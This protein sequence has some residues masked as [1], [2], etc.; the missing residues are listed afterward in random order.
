M[1]DTLFIKNKATQKGGAVS[2]SLVRPHLENSVI[3][4]DNVAEYGQ[5]IASYAY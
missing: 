3:M 1:E 4:I 5:D 2:Y